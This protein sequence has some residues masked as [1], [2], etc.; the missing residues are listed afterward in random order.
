M[1]DKKSV[2]KKL[3]HKLAKAK[4]KL[5]QKSQETYSDWFVNTSTFPDALA[6]IKTSSPIPDSPFL[7]PSQSANLEGIT[8][9]WYDPR[10]DTTDDTKQTAHQL[11]EVN[12]YVIF[13]SDQVQCV[14]YIKSV[15]NEKIFLVMSGKS[16]SNILQEIYKLPQVDSIFIF[17]LKVEKYQDLL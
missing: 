15:N 7:P 13:Y 16:S 9:I 3:G 11:R 8:L 10:L 12:N 17:C 2:M 6:A 1:D 14:D 5:I 4:S